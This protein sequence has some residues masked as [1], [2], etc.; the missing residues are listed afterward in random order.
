[1]SPV[2]EEAHVDRGTLWILQAGIFLTS[3]SLLTVEITLTRV[4]SVVL[5][6]HYVFAVISLALLGLGAGSIFVHF[7]RPQIPRGDNRFGSLALFASLFSLSI[8]FSVILITR[9]AYIASIRD[10]ILFYFYSFS[11]IIPF[12]FAGI[13]LAEVFR[14]FPTISSKIYGADLIGAAA[15]SLAVIFI[16]NVLGGINTSF[17]LGLTASMG[18]L[19][20]AMPVLRKKVTG[21]RISIVSFLIVATLLG[22]NLTGS[23][24]PDVPIGMNPAKQINKALNTPSFE[25][26][27][28]ETR[29]SAFGRSDLVG[30]G[31]AADN[32][33][34]T[35]AIYIDGTAGSYMYRFNGD[36]QNPGLEIDRLKTEHAGY[37]PFYFLPQEERDNAL[38]IGSGGGADV[39]LALM[40]GVR[41]VTAVEVNREMVDIVREYSWYNGGIY[42][43]YDNV[44][45][46]V[47][48]GRNFIKR[49]PGEYDI[50]MLN[51]PFTDSSR[52]REG[53]VL[54]ENFLFTVDSIKDYLEHL[55]DEGRLMVT[56]NKQEEI[57]RL[58]SISL[59]AFNERGV[60]NETAMKHIYILSSR[61]PNLFVIKKTPFESAQMLPRYRKMR[62]LGYDLPSSY[63]PYFSEGLNPVLTAL[64]NGE[65]GIKDLEKNAKKIGF[66]TS[67]VTDN[68]P[69][70]YKLETG[71]PQP[72]PQV[73]W[74]AVT[75]LLLVL[76]LPPLSWARPKSKK[77]FTGTPLRFVG[78]FTMLGIGFMLV[79]ISLIQRFTLFLGQPVLSLA[80]M[81]FSLLVGAG[82]GS[83]CSGRLPSQRITGGIVIASLSIGAVLVGYTFLLP[84]VF[85]QL[86]GLGITIRLIATISI[87][88]PLG[89]LMGFPFPLGIRLLKEI[90]MEN[91]IPWMWG[92]NGVSS[93]LGSVM[94]IVIAISFGFTEALLIGAGCYFVIGL[95]FKGNPFSSPP[96][97]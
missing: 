38:I 13:L 36:F 91:H 29:W 94:T 78:L 82:M 24:L 96:L 22:A 80:I 51:F 66:D 76:L 30:F 35:M 5:S 60:N 86:L 61:Y 90:K 71:L 40:G 58:L 17:F 33:P 50:I 28:I 41:E 12:F 68:S 34:E 79:E 44:N 21:V 57:P 26:K 95:I 9:I 49:Q 83:I 1:M 11:L 73:F 42:T 69:F 87:L 8:P 72:V 77:S 4:L 67:P 15:G 46:V 59:A 45:V 64:S 85:N 48:E 47:D 62:Q 56:S 23:Y 65:I 31:N 10:N 74:L 89:F 7:F 54:T 19:L 55:T 6:Y 92:I 93:V 20:F 14:M 84:F 63:L 16:L 43:D 18:A 37:F 52:S 3:F 32:K 97:R 39:L 81:L 25:G 2:K 70:F 75:M 53:Y 27:I 88:A